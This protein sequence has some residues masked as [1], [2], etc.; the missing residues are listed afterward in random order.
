MPS[1]APAPLRSTGECHS[2]R[3]LEHALPYALPCQFRSAEGCC[4]MQ[5]EREE[6]E[7]GFRRRERFVGKWERRFQLPENVRPFPHIP[8][9]SQTCQTCHVTQCCL[10]Q[11]SVLS[12]TRLVKGIRPFAQIPV[13]YL[14]YKRLVPGHTVMLLKPGRPDIYCEIHCTASSCLTPF[15]EPAALTA[16]LLHGIQSSLSALVCFC[17]Q[18]PRECVLSGS[19][20]ACRLTQSTSRQ[21]WRMGSSRLLCPRQ[22]STSSRA[23]R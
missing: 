15:S 9:L 13:A 6:D 1:Q 22:R 4:A 19:V 18:M 2:L 7:D 5:D 16:P 14:A 3:H 17:C 12:Y 20:H 10:C 11:S 23:P 8:T 21:R